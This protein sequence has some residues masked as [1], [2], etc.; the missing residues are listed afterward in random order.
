MK[1]I[2]IVSNKS[3]NRKYINHLKKI[4]DGNVFYIYEKDKLT[5]DFLNQVR[6]DFIFFIFWS[7]FIPEEIFNNFKCLLFH[8]AALPSGRGGS[9]IQNAI[10]RGKYDNKISCIS[11]SNGIDEGDI[12]L[13]EDINLKIG[14]CSE[15]IFLI[16][17]KIIYKMIPFLIKNAVYIKPKKQSGKVSVYMRRKEEN[18]EIK[19]DF[20]I[21]QIY[22]YIRMLDD[23]NYPG[24]FIRFGKYKLKFSR[25]TYK[26]SKI[27]ADVEII[28]DN[29]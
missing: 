7:W 4:V 17:E 21:D 29:R 18:G 24:A 6:P 8:L 13:Q 28:N 25:A 15:I 26:N 3:I 20:E 2:I 9:P 22:D 10:A 1:N 12:W 11:V 16:I 14:S 5:Y 23:E 27:I 19:S